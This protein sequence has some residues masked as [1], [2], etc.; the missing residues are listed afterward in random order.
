MQYAFVVVFDKLLHLIRD[1]NAIRRPVLSTGNNNILLPV[2]SC[3]F[4]INRL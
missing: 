4:I 1:V 2:S 3:I